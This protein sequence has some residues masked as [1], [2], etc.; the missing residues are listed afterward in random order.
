MDFLRPKKLKSHSSQLQSSLSTP[1]K[2]T[3]FLNSSRPQLLELSV[4]L[5]LLHNDSSL[6]SILKSHY[7]KEQSNETLEYLTTISAYASGQ[8]SESL[9]LA[10][11]LLI[12]RPTQEVFLIILK[13]AVN[14]LGLTDLAH[15]Y[16]LLALEHNPNDETLKT[17]RAV[18]CLSSLSSTLY[19]DQ[20][21][22]LLKEA[23]TLLDSNS[24]TGKNILFFKSITNAQLGLV[25]EAIVQATEGFKI[26]LSANY[27][28]LIALI[29]MAQEDYTGSL[30]IIKRGL[31]ANPAHLL[32]YALK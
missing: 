5:S 17:A 16:S 15:H 32:L 9:F 11:D 10:R 13:I 6:Y 29:M 24:S 27:A 14:H 20:K 19:Q 31:Q 18:V 4:C 23:K 30:A 2:T 28:A 12:S 22:Q 1:S 26:T 3:E 8:Y 25:S 21:T 7:I